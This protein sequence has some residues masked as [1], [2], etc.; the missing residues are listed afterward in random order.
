MSV[1]NT[2]TKLSNTKLCVET[3]EEVKNM[4]RTVNKKRT[5]KVNN[6]TRNNG[7]QSNEQK[8]ENAF[9]KLNQERN[10]IKEYKVSGAEFSAVRLY[11]SNRIF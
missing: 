1:N 3:T 5:N 11:Y 2:L 6:F 10:Q 8:F 4:Y 7:K 9:L